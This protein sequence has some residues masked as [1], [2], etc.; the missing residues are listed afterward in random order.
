MRRRSL[1]LLAGSIAS[2]VFLMGDQSTAQQITR[3]R[4]PTAS[5]LR[6]TFSPYLNLLRA[7]TGVLPNFQQFVQPEVRL[8]NALQRQDR[9]IRRNQEQVRTVNQRID[10]IRSQGGVAP[11][12]VRG[13]FRNFSHFFPGLNSTPRR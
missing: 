4:N 13:E 12:G 3:P 8:L 7:D 11:T 5:T 1:T 9:E 2:L 6:P 10:S